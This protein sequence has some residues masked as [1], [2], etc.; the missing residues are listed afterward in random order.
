MLVLFETAAGFALFK[1]LQ[2]GKL[3]EATDLWQDFSSIEAAESVHTLA[4][5]VLVQI[6]W[7]PCADLSRT[8]TAGGQAQGLQQVREH[9]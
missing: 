5:S 2:E 9:H 6:T 8:C 3:K 7:R 4:T 1:V